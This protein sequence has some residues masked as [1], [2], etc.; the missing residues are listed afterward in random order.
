MNIGDRILYNWKLDRYNKYQF[1]DKLLEGII[2]RYDDDDYGYHG[3][4][5]I[6]LSSSELILWVDDNCIHLDNGYYRDIKIDILLNE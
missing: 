3:S 5:Q 4:Y 1:S 2:I 6:Q